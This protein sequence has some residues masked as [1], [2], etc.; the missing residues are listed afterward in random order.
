MWAYG[1]KIA[2]NGNFW[3]KSPQK[4]YINLSDFY[5]I[6]PRE[7]VP[8]L[9]SHAKFHHCSCKK[10]QQRL[11]LSTTLRIYTS[12]VQSVVLL[13]A[14]AQRKRA[15][16]LY[17]ANVFFN[18]FFLWPPYSPALVNGGSRKFYTW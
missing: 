6:L 13:W 3:Y 5:K 8:Q 2:E 17:F 16:M 11:S 18:L 10:T 15:T 14:P 9:H 7:G 12:L 1:L 4:A